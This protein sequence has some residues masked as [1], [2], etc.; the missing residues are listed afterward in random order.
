[1]IVTHKLYEIMAVADRV[2]VMRS[3]KMVESVAV[4]QTSET[5]LARRMVGRD[6]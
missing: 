1:V 5:D 2:C 3:G 6:V 4:T